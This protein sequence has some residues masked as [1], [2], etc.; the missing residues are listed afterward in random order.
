MDVGFTVRWEEEE[1]V[2]FDLCPGSFW[3][4]GELSQCGVGFEGT[5]GGKRRG[6]SEKGVKRWVE[7]AEVDHPK[8]EAGVPRPRRIFS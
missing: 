5:K 4:A 8:P 1:P 3:V 7:T 2:L 6:G